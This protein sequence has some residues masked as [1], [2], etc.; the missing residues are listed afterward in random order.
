[1]KIIYLLRSE[2]HKVLLGQHSYYLSEIPKKILES[3]M[4]MCFSAYLDNVL[5]LGNITDMNEFEKIMRNVFL[6]K[7]ENN[8]KDVNF[9]NDGKFSINKLMERFT[10]IDRDTL[11]SLKY[12]LLEAIHPTSKIVQTILSEDRVR[13]QKVKN[14]FPICNFKVASNKCVYKEIYNYT[15]IEI[16]GN[17]LN[18]KDF[19]EI[20]CLNY[21]DFNLII[22]EN[23]KD[24]SDF[25]YYISTFE[26]EVYELAIAIY[27]NPDKLHE[28]IDTKLIEICG[29]NRRFIK[30]NDDILNDIYYKNY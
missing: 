19:E 8:K 30:M 13:F 28:L 20:V 21:T 4:N 27:G 6:K 11:Y 9:I 1:M 29:E 15:W 26:T 7:Y 16:C 14:I 5:Y 10:D 17:D 3:H 23:L 22:T 2:T 12:A 24:L 18:G 25:I